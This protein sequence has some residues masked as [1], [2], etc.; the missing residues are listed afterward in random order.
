MLTQVDN[1]YSFML[2]QPFIKKRLDRRFNH[3]NEF[4]QKHKVE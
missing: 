3:K 1:C 4:S 2:N